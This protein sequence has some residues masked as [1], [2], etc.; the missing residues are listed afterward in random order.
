M[1]SFE[2]CEK[3]NGVLD[4][5]H[6][7][8]SA[9][10]CVW[11][12]WWARYLEWSSGCPLGGKSPALM[13]HRPL[14]AVPLLPFG[15]VGVSDKAPRQKWQPPAC[16]RRL[17]IKVAELHALSG[18]RHRCCCLL[19]VALGMGNP[20]CVSVSSP[21]KWGLWPTYLFRCSGHQVIKYMLPISSLF[22]IT[23]IDWDSL[24]VTNQF[25]IILSS[26]EIIIPIS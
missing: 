9:P 23:T 22:L 26:V 16:W 17:I 18:F 2:L 13:D 11:A 21:E 7:N 4:S 20:Y 1:F 3:E 5:N 12:S 6:R 15:Q 25:P 14:R 19:C 10:G 24:S 8:K